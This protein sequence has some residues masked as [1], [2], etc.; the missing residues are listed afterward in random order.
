MKR[1]NPETNAPYKAGDVR[2]DGFIFRAYEKQK[3]LETGFY[4][5]SW[6]SPEAYARF[7]VRS[8]K[9]ITV[10]N[11][12]KQQERLKLI[13][14]YKL[15]KGCER[16]GYREHPCALDFAHKDPK[17]KKF[18]ISK[19]LIR[20]IHMI[21]EEIDKCRILCSNCHRLETHGVISFD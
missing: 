21:Y 16:C 13:S 14:D 11:K 8:Q 17:S 2:E 12:Q 10:C 4:K 3:L 7:R 20:N 18:T 6:L 5:E 19:N 9:S 1:L 15:Q